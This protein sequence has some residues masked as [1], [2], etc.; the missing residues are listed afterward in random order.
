MG[1]QNILF[2]SLSFYPTLPANFST[3]TYDPKNAI[4]TIICVSFSSFKLE[5]HLSK[6]IFVKN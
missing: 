1:T 3:F 5:L 2:S 4:Y 6:Y